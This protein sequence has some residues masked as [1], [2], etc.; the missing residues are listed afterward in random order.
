MDT[1]GNKDFADLFPI[2]LQNRQNFIRAIGETIRH[3]G[4]PRVAA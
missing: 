1:I 2:L 3:I 4:D